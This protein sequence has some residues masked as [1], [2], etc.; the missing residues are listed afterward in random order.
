MST[1]SNHAIGHVSYLPNTSGEQ[2]I[3]KAV[4]PIRLIPQQKRTICK[5]EAP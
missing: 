5:R 2:P 1:S 4:C 3:L